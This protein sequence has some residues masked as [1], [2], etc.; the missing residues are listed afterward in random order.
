MAS[1]RSSGGKGN[2]AHKRMGNT[3]LKARRQASWRR[4]KIRKGARQDAQRER[5]AANRLRRS[6]GVPT[7]WEVAK[8]ASQARREQRAKANL[9][10]LEHVHRGE[11]Q[12]EQ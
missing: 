4:G 3:A 2:P 11:R 10:R 9:A 5:E 1:G 8:A 12:W 6:A 7:P